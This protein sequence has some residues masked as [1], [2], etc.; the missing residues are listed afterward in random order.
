MINFKISD[1]VCNTIFGSGV[2]LHR[3]SLTIE[4]IR[5]S[6]YFISD[7]DVFVFFK[8]RYC[9]IQ[10]TIFVTGYGTL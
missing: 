2:L 5:S 6:F 1:A 10:G 8:S 4:S 9:N 3:E 7:Q